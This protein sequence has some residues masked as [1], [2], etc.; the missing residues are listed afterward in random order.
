MGHEN[1]GDS[2]YEQAQFG[3]SR[4]LPKTNL[5]LRRPEKHLNF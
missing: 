4:I 5:S 1:A 3:F 2:G